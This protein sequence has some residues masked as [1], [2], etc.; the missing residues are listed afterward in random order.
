MREI[1]GQRPDPQS[2]FPAHNQNLFDNCMK[3]RKGNDDDDIVQN[4]F[5]KK[6]L[7]AESWRRYDLGTSR[8]KRRGCFELA[9]DGYASEAGAFCYLEDPR[10]TLRT[11]VVTCVAA[12]FLLGGT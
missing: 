12:A 4:D 2:R 11:I 8:A 10:M 5:V 1:R 6:S 9:R 7:A 3:S